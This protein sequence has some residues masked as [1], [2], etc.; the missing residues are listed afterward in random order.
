MKPLG[1]FYEHVFRSHIQTGYFLIPTIF[2]IPYSDRIFPYCFTG[3]FSFLSRAK[4]MQDP[5][6]CLFH[7]HL[8]V[9]QFRCMPTKNLKSPI[10]HHCVHDI[11]V[12]LLTV[13]YN[14]QYVRNYFLRL[15][16]ASHTFVFLFFRLFALVVFYLH[17]L[18]RIF[19]S[20]H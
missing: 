12:L 7:L 14:E 5:N 18:R 16:R 10:C 1:Y 3:I 13:V 19:L 2:K 11:W 15:Y 20:S 6:F 9:G 8:Q 4:H 17:L